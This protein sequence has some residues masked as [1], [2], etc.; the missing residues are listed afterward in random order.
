MTASDLDYKRCY[1][2]KKIIDIYLRL[3]QAN[4]GLTRSRSA[5]T[6]CGDQDRQLWKLQGDAFTA[7]DRIDEAANSYSKAGYSA[8]SFQQRPTFT[9]SSTYASYSSNSVNQQGSIVPEGLTGDD[10]PYFSFLRNLVLGA[11]FLCLVVGT[12]RIFKKPDSGHNSNEPKSAVVRVAEHGI[13]HVI[14]E[15]LKSITDYILNKILGH[16]S[17]YYFTVFLEL[18]VGWIV[19]HF[20]K[21]VFSL[22]FSFLH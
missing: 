21:P 5:F 1:C 14:A 12:I 8:P 20:I 7:L 9:I 11:M 13:L 19:L 10:D 4:S 18:T 2:E 3:N 22:L 16:T 17:E 6:S 15:L